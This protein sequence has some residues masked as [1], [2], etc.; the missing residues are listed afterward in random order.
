MSEAPA[1]TVTISAERLRELEALEAK[2]PD[3][4][5][6]AKAEAHAERFASL[7]ERDAKDPEAHRKRTKQWK[8]AHREEYNAKRREDY[9]KK[10]EQKAA[11]TS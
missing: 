1:N 2:L 3:I 5:A 10:K 4:V 7:R 9:K 6:K 8:D 11:T